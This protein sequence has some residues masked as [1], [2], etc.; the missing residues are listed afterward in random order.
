MR[1]RELPSHLLISSCVAAKE[2][3]PVTRTL[4]Q[5]TPEEQL[6]AIHRNYLPDA[7]FVHPFCRVPSFSGIHI[8][9]VGTINSRTLILAIFKWY[10]ILS[11]RVDIHIE[12][13]S[14][15]PRVG[16][17]A[18]AGRSML[19]RKIVFDKHNKKLYL[20]ISQVFAIWFIPFYRAPVHLITV[21]DLVQRPTGNNDQISRGSHGSHQGTNHASEHDMPSYAEV[22][23][24]PPS[25]SRQVS[26]STG[27]DDSAVGQGQMQYMIARQEDFYQVNEFL[28]FILPLV[29]APGWA[30]WQIM[31][32]LICAVGVLACWPALHL[33]GLTG[34]PK[35]QGVRLLKACKYHAW[36]FLFIFLFYSYVIRPVM[37]TC[38]ADYV[39]IVQFIV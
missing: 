24:A 37:I 32:T 19:I 1:P 14:K 38:L 27:E 2:I 35:S 20:S 21:I 36:S 8:P 18:F 33:I 3:I 26:W 39:V 10:R 12:S 30:V 29:G 7:S 17:H 25:N 4:C 22:A 9:G 31:S 11:P 34:T 6:D 23:A 28:K 15:L 16:S 13:S 5:G